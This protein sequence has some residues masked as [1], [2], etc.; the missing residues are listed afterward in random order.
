MNPRNNND[1]ALDDITLQTLPA[2]LVKVKLDLSYV[3]IADLT[4]CFQRDIRISCVLSTPMPAMS[5][6]LKAVRSL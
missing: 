3:D 5:D 1:P 4:L 6:F 2:E